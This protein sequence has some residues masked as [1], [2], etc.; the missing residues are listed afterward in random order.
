VLQSGSN[1][2][3]H[4]SA[5]LDTLPELNASIKAGFL[6]AYLRSSFEWLLMRDEGEK[7]ALRLFPPLPPQRPHKSRT[8]AVSYYRGKQKLDAPATDALYGN[9][10]NNLY[11]WVIPCKEYMRGAHILK[12]SHTQVLYV[13]QSEVSLGQKYKLHAYK[14]RC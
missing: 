11:G 8:K 7:G 3:T 14:P 9:H 2:R 4:C 12:L 6:P 13:V 1:K 10:T 5:L